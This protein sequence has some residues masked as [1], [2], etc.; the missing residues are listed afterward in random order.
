MRFLVSIYMI[1][2]SILKISHTSHLNPVIMSNSCLKLLYHK[3]DTDYRS[4]GQSDNQNLLPFFAHFETF[5][6]CAVY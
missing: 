3:T 2:S 5:L 1:P 4:R 6:Y